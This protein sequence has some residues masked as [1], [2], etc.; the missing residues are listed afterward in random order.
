MP[1]VD[2]SPFVIMSCLPILTTWMVWRF[3]RVARRRKRRRKRKSQTQTPPAT[4][5]RL[6]T[7]NGLILLMLLSYVVLAGEIYFR[8]WYEKTDSFS[9]T[10]TSNRWLLKYYKMNGSGYRDNVEYAI[11]R[12]GKRRISFM[13]DSFTAGH[14]IRDVEQRFANLVRQQNPDWE[15]QVL[16]N[17]R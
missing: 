7:G 16:A 9:M 6:L 11:K 2:T 8:Y 15:V 5:G 13:G 10:L 17:N 4:W 1:E 12:S 14:G 3:F